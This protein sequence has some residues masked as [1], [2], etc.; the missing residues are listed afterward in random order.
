M[1]KYYNICIYILLS[2]AS[3]NKLSVA[4][5]NLTSGQR[6]KSPSLQ[7]ANSSL[8]DKIKHATVFAD[9]PVSKLNE[10]FKIQTIFFSDDFSDKDLQ[11]L[12]S[13]FSKRNLEKNKVIH[14]IR[15]ITF[16]PLSENAFRN[17]AFFM[18]DMQSSFGINK[19]TTAPIIL[20]IAEQLKTSMFIKTSIVRRTSIGRRTSMARGSF[21]S[22]KENN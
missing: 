13:I 14:I 4:S 1:N 12:I 8:K 17:S 9:L 5:E 19:E 2:V 22:E 18:K 21:D 7:S 10:T 16:D 11:D 15:G 3:I 20:D 6:T